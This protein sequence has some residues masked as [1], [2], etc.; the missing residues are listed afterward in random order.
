MWGKNQYGQLGLGDNNSRNT[1]Q[2]ISNLNGIKWKSIVEVE[3]KY[4]Q[5]RNLSHL[6]N[7]SITSD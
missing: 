7:D 2:L 4:K 3:K 6:I 5:G 1:P